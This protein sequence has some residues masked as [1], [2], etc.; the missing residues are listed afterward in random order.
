MN[1]DKAVENDFI[2]VEARFYSGFLYKNYKKANKEP[3]FSNYY[4]FET[5]FERHRLFLSDECC[6]EQTKR[7]L[8]FVPHP[9]HLTYS[10]MKFKFLNSCDDLLGYK[11]MF[12]D[13]LKNELETN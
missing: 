3:D 12:I 6:D 7:I 1:I 9:G 5:T 13:D 8:L 4:S 2:Y 11:V 10:D